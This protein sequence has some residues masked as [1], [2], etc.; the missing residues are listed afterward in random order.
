[1]PHNVLCPV[2]KLQCLSR[3]NL[4]RCGAM[5]TL[6]SSLL[7]STACS[8]LGNS[9]TTSTNPPQSLAISGTLPAA[10]KGVNYNAPLTVTGGTA[11]YQF[12]I[13]TGQLPAGLLLSATTGT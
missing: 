12:T 8:L 9:S 10:V 6:V 7:L 4:L 5:V 13:A 2:R 11:P 1:M 3:A